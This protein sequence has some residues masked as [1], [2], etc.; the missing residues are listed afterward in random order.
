LFRW[1]STSTVAPVRSAIFDSGVSV[2]PDVLVAV[3][4]HLAVEVG[5]EHVDDDEP[6]AGGLH[7]PLE[8]IDIGRWSQG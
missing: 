4:V 5:G 2:E 3:A 1:R 7:E 8:P 6:R